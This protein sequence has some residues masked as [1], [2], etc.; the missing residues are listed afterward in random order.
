LR[1]LI[2][3]RNLL[4]KLEVRVESIRHEFELEREAKFRASQL[5]FEQWLAQ[6]P[7]IQEQIEQMQAHLNRLDALHETHIAKAFP[8]SQ[9]SAR[10]AQ[11]HTSARQITDKIAE[12]KENGKLEKKLQEIKEGA[13]K[14]QENLKK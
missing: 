8:D 5:Q 12:L 3:S 9:L 14:L 2:E 1:H 7:D 13:S 11:A 6:R 4:H 10:F